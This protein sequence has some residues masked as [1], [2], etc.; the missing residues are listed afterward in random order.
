MADAAPRAW[1]EKIDMGVLSLA[2]D[3]ERISILVTDIDAARGARAAAA[4]L[5][6]AA[7]GTAGVP[8]DP[9]VAAW[10][11]AYAAAGLAP[12]VATPVEAL[13]AW[14]ARAAGVPSQ[15]TVRDIVHAFSLQHRVPAAA[16][17]A[18]H[19]QGDLW[20]RPSRGCEHFLGFGDA[21][22]SAPALN[23]VILADTG[24]EVLARHWHGRQGR[25]T[26]ADATTREVLV[27][28]D[29]LPPRAADADALA[30]TFVRLI[31]G[32]TGGRADVRRLAWDTP[33]AAWPAPG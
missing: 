18:G 2:P 31:T 13:A 7:A 19:V 33:Q 26:A 25:F 17:A 15:G 3:F 4:L 9:H 12:G 29:L 28:L 27:H 1:R 16:Y 6:R 30:D 8:A 14:A 21:A 5:A 24:D 23:E 11:A 10:R 22:P 20:L 32:F